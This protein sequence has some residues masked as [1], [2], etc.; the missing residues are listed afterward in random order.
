MKNINAYLVGY[1][2]SKKIISAS[3]YLINKYIPN[4]IKTT[5]LNYGSF[6]GEIFNSS[7]T[8]LS[9][10]RYGGVNSWGKNLAKFFKSLDEEILIFGLDDYLLTKKLKEDQLRKFILKMQDSANIANVQMSITSNQLNKK[11]IIN[12]DGFNYLKFDAMYSATTQWTIWRKDILVT[13]LENIKNPWEFELEGSKILNS[14][15]LRTVITDPPI[16]IYPDGSSLSGR[17]KGKISVL[18]NQVKDINNLIKMGYLK[19]EELILG[20]FINVSIPF[21]EKNYNLNHLLNNYHFDEAEKD[22][23]TYI[24]ELCLDQR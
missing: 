13:I 6:K 1:K 8:M 23:L 21:D 17:Q 16:L 10:L 12:S 11:Y 14:L 2:D 19:K 18:G 9:Y 24:F 20:Q 3:G 4:S 5:F 15:N 22:L 7:Y